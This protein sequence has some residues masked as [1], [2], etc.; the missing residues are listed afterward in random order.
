MMV[1]LFLTISLA[2]L[3]TEADDV[4]FDKLTGADDQLGLDHMN[5]TRTVRQGDKMMIR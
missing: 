1:Q 2:S 3:L 4:L 5:K